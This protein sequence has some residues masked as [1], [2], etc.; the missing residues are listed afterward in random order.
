MIKP[1][2]KRFIEVSYMAYSEQKYKNHNVMWAGSDGKQNELSAV[3]LDT[4]KIIKTFH[5]DIE[6]RG[7]WESM[8]LG[9]CSS[10]GEE[11]CIYIGNVGNNKAQWCC[12]EYIDDQGNCEYGRDHVEVYKFV[13][14]DLSA[15]TSNR[16]VKVSTLILDYHHED[17]PSSRADCETLF[18]DYTGDDAGGK[19]GDMY[20]VTKFPGAQ[21]LQRVVKVPVEIHEGLQKSEKIEFSVIPVGAPYLK[22]YENY[23]TG[24]DMT[25]DG[26]MIALRDYW[27]VHFIP[28]PRT[29]SIGQALERKPCDFTSDT[30]YD[31][32]KEEAYFEAVAMMGR[33]RMAET[34]ECTKKNKC[35]VAITVYRLKYDRIA[36]SRSDHLFPRALGSSSI[37]G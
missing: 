27:R 14:P 31:I 1:S 37:E 10:S 13:E 22:G 11:V 8:S 16:N 29:L 9:P 15:Q 33:K 21:H 3:D 6:E 25:T 32:R 36:R 34:H 28:R 4:G 20:L 24:G 2:G 19:Q 18:L 30:N 7:D 12:E 5:L 23:W 26:T 17:M 35:T